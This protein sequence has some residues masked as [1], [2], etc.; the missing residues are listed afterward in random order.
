[1][2]YAHAHK[3]QDVPHELGDD[4]SVTGMGLLLLS[5]LELESQTF[6]GGETE[7]QSVNI[8][9]LSNGSAMEAAPEK[10]P[11]ITIGAYLVCVRA[12]NSEI[13]VGIH[14]KYITHTK[15]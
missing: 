9:L 4:I 1:M 12:K 2:L 7:K 3:V 6:C 15:K 10:Y 5:Q 13:G 14:R 11:F 8:A